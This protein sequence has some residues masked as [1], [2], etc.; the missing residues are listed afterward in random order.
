[1][2]PDVFG[3]L[4]F[5]F[6][7]GPL[8]QNKQRF[9][10]LGFLLENQKSKK[11]HCVKSGLVFVLARPKDQ[12]AHIFFPDDLSTSLKNLKISFSL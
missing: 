5:F 12:L 9:C 2:C 3:F 10:W 8:V 1:M 7:F 4:L 11:N 6:N